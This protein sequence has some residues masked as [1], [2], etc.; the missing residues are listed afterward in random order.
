MDIKKPIT[1][2]ARTI[3]GIFGAGNKFVNNI[4]KNLS[5]TAYKGSGI[6][7]PSKKPKKQ[8]N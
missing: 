5:D 7:N 2:T 3:G 1:D 4:Y 6:P 8:V